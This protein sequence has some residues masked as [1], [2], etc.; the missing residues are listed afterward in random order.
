MR[1]LI[2][3]AR[4]FG[5]LHRQLRRRS[6]DESDRDLRDAL[7][8]GDFYWLLAN[9]K[10]RGPIQTAAVPVSLQ[11][12]VGAELEEMASILETEFPDYLF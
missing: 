8:T 4:R 6:L 7:R 11:K 2:G 10:A 9:N 12:C 1:G 5:K 3:N